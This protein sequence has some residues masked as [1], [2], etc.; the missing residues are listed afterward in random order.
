MTESDQPTT[1][2][3]EPASEPPQASRRWDRAPT[4]PALLAVI[5]LLVGGGVGYAIGHHHGDHGG[6]GRHAFAVAGFG[7]PIGNGGGV[8]G[9]AFGVPGGGFGSSQLVQGTL[10]SVGG[11]K[12][13]VKS[14]NGT[15]ASYT[16]VA[17]TQI[18]RND[19]VA[20]V[21][22]LRAADKVVLEVT[23]GSAG[24]TLLERVLAGTSA[25]APAGGLIG[26]PGFDGPAGIIG[27]GTP[28]S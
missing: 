20:T 4:L 24:G 16:V 13:T 19:K 22:D 7:D 2:S 1:V 9:R 6:P 12:L 27:P 17:S 25:T 26:P 3:N 21:S 10:S 8:P 18:V 28:A 23:E 14:V 11:S 15:T 5:G